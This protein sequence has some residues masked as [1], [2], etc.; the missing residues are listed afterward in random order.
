MGAGRL[1][2]LGPVDEFCLDC[3]ITNAHALLLPIQ[4][5]GGSNVKTAEALLSGRPMVATATAMRGFDGFRNM[6]GITL[7]N[8]ARD[9]GAAMLAV[10]DSPFQGSG[11]DHPA[12]SELLWEATITPLVELMREIEGE[13]RADRLHALSSPGAAQYTGQETQ[14]RRCAPGGAAV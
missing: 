6:P 14:W 9:F 10:L 11:A 13:M 12:L 4:Y 8:D 5:G 3:A 2:S 7:A 1:I